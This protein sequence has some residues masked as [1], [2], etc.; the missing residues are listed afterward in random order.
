[1]ADYTKNHR[2]SGAPVSLSS[3]Y[4]ADYDHAI[5]DRSLRERIVFSDHS[6]ATDTVFAEVHLVS[7]RNL[8]IYFDRALQ[9]R[10]LGLFRDSLVRR[11]FLGLGSQESVRFS[12]Y[13]DAFVELPG[14]RR[15]YRRS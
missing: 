12:R 15:W 8:L 2:A 9:D 3:Y 13:A 1:M 4:L 7:C 10:A 11:G 5:F 14:T 6:L